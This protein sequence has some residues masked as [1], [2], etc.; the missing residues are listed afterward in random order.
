MENIERSKEVTPKKEDQLGAHSAEVGNF[1]KEDV[2]EVIDIKEYNPGDWQTINKGLERLGINKKMIKSIQIKLNLKVDGKVGPETIT[3]IKSF[4]ESHDKE[5]QNED[6]GLKKEVEKV[7]TPAWIEKMRGNGGRDVVL[8]VSDDFDPS[9]ETEVI[10]HFH[11]TDG[12]CFGE[13]PQLEGTTSDYQKRAGTKSVAGNRLQQVANSLSEMKGRNVI[14]AYPISAGQRGPKKTIAY[15]NG[16]DLNWMDRE[17]TNE[18]INVLHSEVIDSVSKKFGKR[19]NVTKRT[20]K[21]HSAGGM[22][23]KN[24][25]NSGFHID[26]V[27]FLDA[28]YG[29]WAVKCY[30]EAI[31]RNPNIEFNIVVRPGTSTENSKTKSLIGLK[32]VKIIYS[33]KKHS[34]MNRGYFAMS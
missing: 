4:E 22:A 6:E 24:L 31:K 21:G 26:R 15:R 30:E 28:S 27:D 32:G 2:K 12:H 10:Y 3:A 29:D 17:E 16:Y 18:D 20:V 25:S 34:D 9:K 5:V 23:L 33:D 19:V 1:L 8:M 14:V 11:G 13:L 7:P